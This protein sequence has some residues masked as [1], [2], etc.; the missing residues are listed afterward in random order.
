MT[1]ILI[2]ED[3]PSSSAMLVGVAQRQSWETVAC[4]HL[5]AAWQRAAHAT[6][7]GK[8]ILLENDPQRGA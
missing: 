3:D 6:P 1:R 8:P 2:V 7:H 4:D 5:A